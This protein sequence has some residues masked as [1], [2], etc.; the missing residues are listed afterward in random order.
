MKKNWLV[1][2]WV[3]S[4]WTSV[5]MRSDK[6]SVVKE[7]RR[8]EHNKWLN[9]WQGEK[10]YCKKHI[11]YR[12]FGKHSFLMSPKVHYN[13]HLLSLLFLSVERCT[14]AWVA[15]EKLW[16]QWDRILDRLEIGHM[17]GS[18]WTRLQVK[19]VLI[20]GWF[21]VVVTT[22]ACGECGM[23]HCAPVPYTWVN[24]THW[25]S[26]MWHLKRQTP[27]MNILMIEHCEWAQSLCTYHW[28]SVIPL[29]M[30]IKD[31]CVISVTVSL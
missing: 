6:K 30:I 13:P 5:Y 25:T 16:C 20:P 24:T 27:P 22:F 11:A 9:S 26:Q 10:I 21:L 3:I 2:K 28:K 8:T 4:N 7:Q 18:L 15:G 17:L 14:L 1:I 19:F 12:D 31:S 23:A 29:M